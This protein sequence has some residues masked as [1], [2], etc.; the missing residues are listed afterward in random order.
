MILKTIGRELRALDPM[1]NSGL[2][3]TRVTLSHELISLNA[4]NI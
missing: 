3:M 2:L 4:M 1:N